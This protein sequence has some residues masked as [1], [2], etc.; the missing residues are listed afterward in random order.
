[1]RS[2]VMGCAT[3]ALLVMAAGSAAA[4]APPKGTPDISGLWDNNEGLLFDPATGHPKGCNANSTPKCYEE[5]PYNAVW[6]AKYDAIV[7]AHSNG[8]DLVDPLN[9]CQP[10]GFP[11]SLGGL[12][13]PIDVAQTGKM[14]YMTWEYMSSIH[15]IY[16]NV[17]HPPENEMWPMVMGNAVGHWEGDTLVVDTVSMKEGVFDRTQA[18]HSDKVHTVERIR[19]VGNQL[20]DN[21]TIEDPVAFTKPWHVV[22]HYDKAKPDTRIGDLYCDSDRNPVVDGKVQVVLN[23]PVVAPGSAEHDDLARK[24]AQESAAAMAA[25]NAPVH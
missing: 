2:V 22:R 25:K 21:I 20:V 17:P 18:P 10:P 16:M 24:A 23:A 13:G 4:Q 14:T 12:P 11:R 19:R 15:R 8:E 6:Q 7:K 3:A 5:P 1:M 9:F